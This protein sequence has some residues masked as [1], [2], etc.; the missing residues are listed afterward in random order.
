MLTPI[1]SPF[2]SVPNKV[3]NLRADDQTE[4]SVTLSWDKPSGGVDFYVVKFNDQLKNVRANR[5]LV[6]EL[7]PGSTY[8]FSIVSA[9]DSETTRSEESNITVFT[10]EFKSHRTLHKPK[11]QQTA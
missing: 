10:S 1:V 2:Y 4:S 7:T 9:V 11:D 8:T 6:K 3:D 5:T